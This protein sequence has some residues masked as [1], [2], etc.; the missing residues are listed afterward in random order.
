MTD[1]LSL[2]L[3]T[4]LP[5]P[6][7]RLRPMLP[8]PLPDPFDSAD[9]L[10][11]P[12]WGGE[13]VLAFVEPA[14]RETESGRFET[15]DGRASL[16]LIDAG[17]RDLA[18]RLPELA[19]AP[20]RVE[21]GSAVLDGELVVVGPM[22]RPDPDALAARLDGRPGPDVALLVFDILDLDGRPL[23][24]QPLTR[25]RE[26]LRRVLRPGPE[27][28]ALPAI[29]G[30]GIAL[31][32][33]VIAQGLAGML[34]R[35]RAS[36]YLPGVRSRLWRWI[37]AKPAPGR[38]ASQDSASGAPQ[39]PDAADRDPGAEDRPSAGVPA[40][41]RRGGASP[42]PGPWAE[43]QGAGTGAQGAGTGPVDAE[44]TAEGGTAAQTAIG[45][46]QTAEA[47]AEGGTAA[48]VIARGGTDAEAIAEGG[49]AAGV[50]AVFR[51]LPL[52]PEDE[53]P[54]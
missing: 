10:F 6:S 49:T 29:A 17:G 27:I 51:R 14:V 44:S 20:L 24:G 30:E 40:P 1:Q 43:P 7:S 52:E 9:H 16:R 11:E 47:A 32:D 21:A 31:Y 13:R 8:R 46:G 45:D 22:G 41:R 5:R 34:A 35:Q 36:P 28:V 23:I 26:A 25:R 53:E 54:A 50:I 2:E 19:A 3:A 33:A 39:D 15:A 42:E 4:G 38:S 18:E 48:G 12:S 37:A